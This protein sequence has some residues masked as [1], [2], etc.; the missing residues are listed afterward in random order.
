MQCWASV[1][2]RGV[3]IPIYVDSGNPMP[4]SSWPDDVLPDGVPPDDGRRYGVSAQ[5]EERAVGLAM[6]GRRGW[7]QRRRTPGQ[8]Y[9]LGGS[10]I[11]NPGV[12][13]I[14]RT[15]AY[16]ECDQPGPAIDVKS[17]GLAAMSDQQK[18]A[19]GSSAGHLTARKAHRPW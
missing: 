3:L 5:S 11:E 19:S 7:L 6:R 14:H 12:V 2:V 17:T 15:L 13:S 4:N 16:A 18:Y 10:V 9:P 1:I 8:V